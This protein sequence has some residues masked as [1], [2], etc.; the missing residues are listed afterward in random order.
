[1]GAG[2]S[3]SPGADVGGGEPS[4]GADAGRVSPAPE[5]MW[6]GVSPAPAQ[7]LHHAGGPGGE[8]SPGA[9]AGGVELRLL[10]AVGHVRV[11]QVLRAHPARE[12]RL[13]EQRLPVRAAA[14][15]QGTP[16]CPE[17]SEYPS[18]QRHAPGACLAQRRVL[19]SPTE[20]S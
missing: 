2:V 19:D 13:D 18:T 3:P 17:Y 12:H 10:L 1:M 8:P 11:G 7:M 5:Q 16:Q 9:D 20:E 6:A 15:A 14:R 4:P